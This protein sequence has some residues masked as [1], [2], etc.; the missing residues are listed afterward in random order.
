MKVKMGFVTNS[1]SCS[2]VMIG[3]QFTEEEIKRIEAMTPPD[4]IGKLHYYDG[5]ESG[6][7]NDNCVLVGKEVSVS[8]DW[9]FE[10]TATDLSELANDEDIQVFKETFQI[11]KPLQLICS[12]R[13]C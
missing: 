9:G 2:F 13:M 1:S 3:W 11:D 4:F 8:E 6:A 10:F 7:E 5:E 12:T